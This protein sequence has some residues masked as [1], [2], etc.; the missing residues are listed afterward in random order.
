MFF[1]QKYSFIQ[2]SDIVGD[3]VVIQLFQI[4]KKWGSMME[5]S[6]EILCLVFQHIID[7]KQVF[8]QKGRCFRK[9][10]NDCEG[11]SGQVIFDVTLD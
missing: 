4:T 3:F 6:L 1:H 11:V 9:L 2:W 8:G 7:Q 10:F 5:Y